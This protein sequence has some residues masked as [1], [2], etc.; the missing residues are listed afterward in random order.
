MSEAMQGAM[1][2]QVVPNIKL[3]CE[4]GCGLLVH[5]EERFCRDCAMLNHL[6]EVK[7]LQDERRNRSYGVG[8]YAR[9]DAGIAYDDETGA[10]TVGYGCAESS[11]LPEILAGMSVSGHFKLA[12]LVM[13]GV[14]IAGLGLFVFGL[15]VRDVVGWI[16]GLQ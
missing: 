6:L 13:A 5:H 14:G 9:V 7:R 4:G 1:G 2:R 10:M 15:G 16:L 11:S 12:A 8:E 3:D